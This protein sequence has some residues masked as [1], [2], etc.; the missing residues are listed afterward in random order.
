[1]SNSWTSDI[2]G[3]ELYKFQFDLTNVSA[4]N[5][6][7]ILQNLSCVN[8]WHVQTPAR[9]VYTITKPVVGLSSLT[10]PDCFLIT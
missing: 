5:N 1:M 3:V 2:F 9:Q 6:V 8:I 7:V 4:K 10:W